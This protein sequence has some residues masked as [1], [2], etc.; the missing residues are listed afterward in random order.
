[1]DDEPLALERLGVAFRNIPNAE[2]VG[3]ASDGEEAGER[4]AALKPDLVILDVQMPGRN[5]M[6]VA[7]ALPEETRPEI[8]FVT[9]FEHYAPEAFEVE[10]ADYLLKPV[11]FDR[12]RLA[13]E[14][15]GRRR[16]MREATGRA[17]E[18][19]EVVAALR[20]DARPKTDGQRYDSEVWVPG[21]HGLTRVDVQRIDWIEA[22]RDY[23]LLHT[24]TR[25][26]IL[27][28]TMSA[29]QERL[30][31][32]VMM[33]VHRSAFVRHDAVAEVQKPGKG[34]MTLV[35]KD[36]AEVQVGPNYAS[37]VAQALKLES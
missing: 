17:A 32:A 8:I 33:R 20:A 10:A 36:G 7:S 25:S 27:R 28:T 34:L 26:H 35:L 30:D 19:E 18:L 1:V 23:V 11:R 15:A 22:A 2:V 6:A 21:R 5:G 3:T 29:L 13:V 37:A 4:I 9:A 16:A 12:L 24:S 14:R 31:P